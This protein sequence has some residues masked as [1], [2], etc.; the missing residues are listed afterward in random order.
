MDETSVLEYLSEYIMMSLNE[1]C[2]VE[3]KTKFTEGSF[4]AFLE[5]LEVIS[6]WSSFEKY[7]INDIEKHFSFN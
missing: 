3:H 5:C 4:W 6:K 2:G 7:G 1:L